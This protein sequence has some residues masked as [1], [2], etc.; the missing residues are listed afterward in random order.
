MAAYLF[1]PKHGAPPYQTVIYHPG[2]DALQSRSREKMGVSLIFFEFLMLSGRAVLF[3]VYEGSYER[4]IDLG[5]ILAK[6]EMSIQEVKDAARSVD[7]LEIRADIDHR[8]I[9]FYGLSWG[10]DR[11]ARI[12]GTENRFKTCVLLGR[13]WLPFRGRPKWTGS[14]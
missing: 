2:C 7:Y 6:R 5:G 1:L 9:A 10:A 8:R 11:G 13:G 4:H 14:T 12:C 3:P